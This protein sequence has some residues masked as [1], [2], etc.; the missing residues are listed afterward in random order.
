MADERVL[1]EHY[2]VMEDSNDLHWM[3]TGSRSSAILIHTVDAGAIDLETASPSA[4]SCQPGVVIAAPMLRSQRDR[5][6]GCWQKM[7]VETVT[8]ADHPGTDFATSAANRWSTG[9]RRSGFGTG[10]QRLAAHNQR[11][12]TSPLDRL[13][14]RPIGL[15]PPD[16]SWT[17]LA[18]WL[19]RLTSLLES[20]RPWAQCT[21]VTW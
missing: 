7:L 17:P 5:P 4:R 8:F 3:K 16:R 14:L 15:G 10:M 12:R 6:K 2:L 21:L 1:T 11:R 9:L 20:S 13:P 18:C 19:W